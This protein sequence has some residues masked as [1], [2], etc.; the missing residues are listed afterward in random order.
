MAL[1]DTGIDKEHP[2]FAGKRVTELFLSGAVDEN[3]SAPS[4]GTAVASVIVA[5]PDSS[6]TDQVDAAR[7]VAW[8]ADITMFAI[9]ISTAVPGTDYVPISLVSLSSVDAGWVFRARQAINWSRRRR[10]I[11]FV[12]VSVG[13]RGIIDQ[14]D[15]DELRDN[16]GGAIAA[17]AQAGAS[18]K[19]V[20]VW[21]AGNAH[22]K[23]CNPA[24]FSDEPELCEA[25]DDSG[26]T[27]HRVVATSVQVLPGLTARITELR[28][29]NIAVVAIGEDGTIAAFSNRCGIAAQWCLA[30][31][32]ALVRTAYFGPHPDMA[33]YAARG[34]ATVNG[35]SFAAPMVVGALVVMKHYFRDE[36][37]NT[38]LVER[39]LT[40]ANRQG[41][42]ADSNTYGQGLLDLAAAT[43]PAGT[44]RIVLSSLVEGA[45][46]DPAETKLV[47]GGAL[48]D[49]LTRALAGQ[50]IAVFDSL[51]AP[52]WYA[53]GSFTGAADGPSM[54]ARLR[55]F[56]TQPQ[57][58]R[59][60]GAWRPAL[61]AVESGDRPADPASLR[62][63]LLDASGQ[64]AGGHLSLA[65]R[66]LA[67]STTGQGGLTAAAFSTEGL[68]GRAPVSG[69][70]L[71]WRP[72][73]A[74]LGLRGGFVGEREALLGSRAAGAFG[75]MAAGSAFAGIEGS[76]RLGA[77]RLGAGAEVGTV[78]ASAQGGLIADLSPLTTS[79][80]A[81]EAKRPLA[82]AGV[83]TLALSQPLRVEAGRARLSVPVGRTK[84][85]RVRR[86]TVTA[87]LAP[88]GRQIELAVEWRQRLDSGGELRLG[89]AWTHDPGH[90]A[91]ADPD[92]T[93]LA[94]WRQSF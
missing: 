56:M 32:G 30:A 65:G 20:F 86:Q 16:F 18:D 69:A 74:P 37:Y 79:A 75:R 28:E 3:G 10:T 48:G 43:S 87:D 46:V 81:V 91:T 42:Y 83:L 63:G 33:N 85:G 88:T 12:N 76:A 77:W 7:G 60:S 34:A 89:A 22:G 41:I 35:T 92:L 50:E 1:I 49:G 5:R 67:L 59:W 24:D 11:D 2:V 52:F 84:D 40:T 57:T 14:Y 55:G 19:T 4:H 68:D 27:K 38:D 39:L 17:L 25:Y 78:N 29:N 66:A 70:M 80:F 45:G 31:P 94:G 93:L 73:G 72:D 15:A 6:F 8:G 54:T 36:L 58:G 23:P 64:G 90:A 61:G 47:L 71:S 13:H 21:A 62:L 26:V 51:G 82:D 9:P 44:T 53:L